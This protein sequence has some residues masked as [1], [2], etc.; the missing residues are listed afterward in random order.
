[1][2]APTGIQVSLHDSTPSIN[3]QLPLNV[4]NSSN[5][6]DDMELWSVSK[7]HTL[8]ETIDLLNQ[9]EN[10]SFSIVHKILEA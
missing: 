6:E 8:Y 3:Q 2:L 1:M 10:D 4:S 7:H 5:Q 9:Y